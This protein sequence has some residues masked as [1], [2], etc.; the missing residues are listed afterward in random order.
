[1]P[2]T[3]LNAVKIIVIGAVMMSL[4]LNFTL[5]QKQT[6]PRFD[7]LVRSD[8]FSAFAGN[9]EALQRGMAKCEEKLK[10]E[11]ENADA[12]VWHGAGLMFTAASLFQKGDFEK[13]TAMYQQG[14]A[15]L[16]KAKELRPKDL[17]I[18]VARAPFYIAY[19][20]YVPNKEQKSEM[21]RKAM[22]DYEEA[23]RQQE[24]K[25][26][27]LSDHSRGELLFGLT[28]AYLRLGGTENRSKA[29]VLLQ[30]LVNEKAYAEEADKW[31]KAAPDS[32]ETTY[33]HKCV[34]CHV[35]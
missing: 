11:P 26:A 31:M 5:A 14:D 30:R 13:G 28:E 2:N 25:L 21:L 24:S 9:K 12:L 10:T 32:Q 16:T 35:Q 20:R 3:N 18:L 6:E 22:E 33:F 4:L 1:M 23:Y 29:Q 8:F 27:T 19:S 17:S 15:E 34:G 7:F